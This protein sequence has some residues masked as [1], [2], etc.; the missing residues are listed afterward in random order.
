VSA[1]SI[2]KTK[3][4]KCFLTPLQKILSRGNTAQQWL[5]EYAVNPDGRAVLQQAIRDM[6]AQEIDL[7][8]KLCQ[9][10]G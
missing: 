6:E 5:M 3:G 7:A 4:F 9:A 8:H 2:A 10:V 1:S